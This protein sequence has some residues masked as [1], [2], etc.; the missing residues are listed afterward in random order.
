MK[1]FKKYYCIASTVLEIEELKE[2][3]DKAKKKSGG[4]RHQRKIQS[5]AI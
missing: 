1:T 2:A 3:L 4:F 5:T